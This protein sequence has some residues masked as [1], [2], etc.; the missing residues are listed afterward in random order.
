MSISASEFAK[1]LRQ[2]SQL[3][4][5]Q[6][7]QALLETSEEVSKIIAGNFSR[8]EDSQ[9]RPWPKHSALTIELHGV[10]ELLVLSGR[11]RRAA[12]GG[13]GALRRLVRSSGREILQLGI[14]KSSVPYFAAH[15]YGQGRIPRREFFYLPRNHRTKVV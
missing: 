6:G 11:L 12:S 9:G 14:S 2:L 7:E 1:R 10:H 4:L 3:P 13:A 15:Q 5:V 8:K